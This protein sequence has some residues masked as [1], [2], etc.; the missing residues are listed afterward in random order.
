MGMRIYTIHTH[1]GSTRWDRSTH[2]PQCPYT[3]IHTHIHAYIHIYMHTYIYTH[4]Y[5]YTH[6]NT[7]THRI[8]EMGS[9]DAY[10]TVSILEAAHPEA[11]TH[12]VLNETSPVWHH[13]FT[14]RITESMM[15]VV[16][17]H[18]R[19]CMCVY[20]YVSMYVY[21]CMYAYVRLE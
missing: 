11:R 18:T 12:V 1:T 20:T 19:M 14:F 9:I 2:M 10:A 17:I 4:I 13:E 15:S 3:C 6:T 7:H 8:D 21:I 16:S 5:I